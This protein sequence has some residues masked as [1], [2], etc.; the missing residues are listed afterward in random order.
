M[1]IKENPI[2]DKATLRPSSTPARLKKKANIFSRSPRP[3][4]AIGKSVIAPMI[5]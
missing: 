3:P 4:M 2:N 5:G 1:R